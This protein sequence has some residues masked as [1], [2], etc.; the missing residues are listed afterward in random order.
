M[1]HDFIEAQRRDIADQH[2][3]MAGLFAAFGIALW[4]ASALFLAFLIFWRTP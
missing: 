2:D 4:S 1:N 3:R